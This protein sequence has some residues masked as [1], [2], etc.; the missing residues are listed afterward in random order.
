MPLKGYC[1]AI[2]DC[3][4]GNNIVTLWEAKFS[5]DAAVAD[6]KESLNRLH[7]PGRKAIAHSVVYCHP[8]VRERG[9]L[10]PKRRFADKVV[11]DAAFM[12][13][14]VI[15]DDAHELSDV[16]D[17]LRGPSED[18]VFLFALCSI[19]NTAGTP[20]FYQRGRDPTKKRRQARA[21]SEDAKNDA[22]CKTQKPS[23]DEAIYNGRPH[24]VTGPSISIFHPIFQ[25]FSQRLSKPFK[26][27]DY[28]REDFR[29]ANE[30]LQKSA[31]YYPDETQRQLA[32]EPLFAHFLGAMVLAPATLH[33]GQQMFKPDG[34]LHV[35]CG[36]F[37]TRESGRTKMCSDINEIN[38][39]VGLGG[40]DPMEQAEKD[41]VL[42]CTAPELQPLRRVSCM[43]AFLM[44]V[45]GPSVSISGAVYLDGAVIGHFLLVPP[46]PCKKVPAG[47]PSYRDQHIGQLVHTFRAL[48]RCLDDL[49]VCYGQMKPSDFSNY[50]FL[51]APHFKTFTPKNFEPVQ[52]R[53]IKRLNSRFIRDPRS[54]FFAEASGG[55]LQPTRCVVKFT[56]QYCKEAHE[57]MFNEG[58]AARL[59]HCGWE[60]SVGMYVVI[61]EFLEEP[62]HASPS[63]EGLERLRKAL[64]TFHRKGFVFGDLRMPNIILDTDGHPRLIDFEWSGR[65]G[66]VQY[67]ANLNTGAGFPEG[68]DTCDFITAEHDRVMLK[69]YEE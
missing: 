9:H 20:T 43:P 46:T 17:K 12:E 31:A 40:C 55:F 60:D 27:T 56:S 52:L 28:D 2:V 45:T 57:L 59:L 11:I 3:D 66:E 5:D 67:P 36:P 24:T 50:E 6:L 41:Y 37:K 35:Q 8:I 23:Q 14:C 65:E 61:T 47:Y 53:Y 69:K 58:V 34:V 39:G 16:R 1:I 4:N 7:M 21:P 68:V 25:T 22:L 38:N 42:V 33:S 18:S 48:R 30:L 10:L 62:K 15:V 44:A 64:E 29:T 19:I 54:I 26:N 32:I 51:P 49:D 13:E 63:P